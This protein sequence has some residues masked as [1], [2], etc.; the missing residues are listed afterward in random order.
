MED[1]T[2]QQIKDR[3]DIVEVVGNYIKL[4]KTGVNYRA[5]CPFHSEKTPS[6]F[7]SPTRQLWH[8]F[9]SCGTG[10]DIF[11]F[12][13]KIEGLEFGDALRTLAQKAG[14]E[15]ARSSFS[16]Q[17][18]TE[19]AR[20]QEICGLASRFFERQLSSKTGQGA[21]EYLLGRGI[22]EQSIT[23]FHLG[24][25]PD[26]WQGLSDFLVGQSYKREE[27]EKAGL[28]VKKDSGR[29]YD[30]FRG[31]IIFPIF[32]ANS[33]AIGFGGRVFKYEDAA[34]Y[35][36]TPATLLYDKSRVLYGLDKAKL[37][38]RK[39][40]FVILVEGYTDVIMLH[41]AGFINAV[42]TS[43]TALTPFQLKILKRYTDNLYIAFDMDLAGNSA[44]K[45]GIDLAQAEGFNI[46]VITMTPGLDPADMVKQDPIQWAKQ[47]SEAK[48]IMQF[49]FE[50]AL[51]KHNSKTPEGKKE[52]SK[53]LLPVIKRIP[54]KIEQVYWIQELARILGVKEDDVREELAKIKI[55]QAGEAPLP[56][57]SF[58][59][60]N[61][62]AD[63]GAAGEKITRKDLL[64]E[65]LLSLLFKN[66]KNTALIADND[67]GLFSPIACQA[68]VY[69]Q[70]Q[71]VG[72]GGLEPLPAVDEYLAEF[73]NR[74]VLRAELE[75]LKEE[76]VE[77]E[78]KNCLAEIKCLAAK[79][80]LNQ[81]SRAV[82]QAE[83]EGETE[84]IQELM[85]EFD[86]LAREIAD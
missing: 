77:P 20:L 53:I 74:L 48:S 39:N 13:M 42:S 68:F 83:S 11:K 66:P 41:Q 56:D 22:T 52:I 79:R 35:V 58:A 31:R 76:D 75:E 27:V 36:N 37:E 25:S 1:S 4:Q 82:K 3:L 62:L 55:S 43:G 29:S 54:D 63:R 80:E 5:N 23:D 40:D 16:V 81:L 84:K 32:D 34:K 44:T 21:K 72:A 14:V 12:V 57:E 6:F 38:I 86:K 45:R 24:Y 85:K 7:V 49:Y 61:H 64:E 51:A 71:Q 46:K 8:C 19:R 59:G 69:W 28:A 33:Q 2:I 9:G 70:K 73:I 26:T 10:G 78:I 65:R 18:K 47:V 15:I 60:K 30:R 67:Q 17:A 50:I